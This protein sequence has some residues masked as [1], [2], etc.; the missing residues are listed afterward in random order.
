MGVCHLI[1]PPI[2]VASQPNTLMPV[3]TAMII[4]AA[5]KYARLSMSS[6]TVNM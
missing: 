3:G 2:R 5:V 1:C 4:V 6:P